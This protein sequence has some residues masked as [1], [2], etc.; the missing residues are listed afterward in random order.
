MDSRRRPL[1]RDFAKALAVGCQD[2]RSLEVA[3][4]RPSKAR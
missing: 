3:L 4:A 2:F 1:W